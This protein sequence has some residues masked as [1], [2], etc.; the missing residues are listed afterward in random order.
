MKRVLLVLLV[1]AVTAFVAFAATPIK[2]G[3]VVPLGDI[4]GD[5]SAKAMKLAIDEINAAGG[6]L[7]RPLELI[8]V[9]SEL[10]PEKGAAAIEKLATVD[11]VDFFVGGMASSVHLAQIP[12]MKRYQKGSVSFFV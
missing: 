12:V 5:Q 4:T 8:V 10:K 6:L 2:I 7:G 1:V 9:D 11:K 3:A